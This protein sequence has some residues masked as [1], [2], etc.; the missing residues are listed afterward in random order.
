LQPDNV[1]AF[2]ENCRLCPRKCGVN[3]A[4]ASKQGL[5]FCGETHQLRVAYIGPHLGEEPPI[6]GKHGSGTVFLTGCSLKCSF[7]Q[8]HQISRNALG[9]AMDL[10]TLLQ[11]VTRMIRVQQVHNVS[12]VTPDH[13]F[14]HV[15]A[16]VRLL[17]EKGLALP[18]VYNLSGYQSLNLLRRAERHVDIYLPDFKY[19]DSALA[20]RLSKCSNYPAV[21]LRSITEMVRQKG[22]LDACSQ[23]TETAAQGVL[24]R[25]LILPGHLENSID[26]LTSLF[27][28]FGCELPVSLMSQYDPVMPQ[29]E[30]MLN[31]FLSR[32]EFESV[33]KYAVELGFKY[34][35]VQFLDEEP[36]RPSPFLPDFEQPNPFEH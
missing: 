26:V 34:L 18:I 11:K 32:K 24:V 16:L 3:R 22:Y 30:R 15:F 10:E 21:A 29:K 7:C 20:A 35:F 17:R 36:S 31:R 33:Y 14:P 8:N 28:E 6:S 25:H 4:E 9:T 13:F 23:E 27:V 12:F 1:L 2:Y 19:A 5:G